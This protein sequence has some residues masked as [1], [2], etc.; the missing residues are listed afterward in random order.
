M[1]NKYPTD[2]S[3]LFKAGETILYPGNIQAKHLIYRLESGFIRIAY[4]GEKG[5][6]LTLRHVF[7]GEYFG[8]ESLAGDKRQYYVRAVLDSRIRPLDT[9]EL[10]ASLASELAQNFTNAI[11]KTYVKIQCLSSQRLRNRIAAALLELATSPIAQRDHRG[12]VILR[13]T[14]DELASIIGS[15]RE[16]TTKTLGEL[17]RDGLLESG[18]GYLRLLDLNRLKALASDCP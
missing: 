16:T 1:N 13:V 7:P 14:H 2:G 8:E 18:Y 10:P 11:A 9:R 4:V 6:V 3:L 5:E 15:V 17:Y 12:Q